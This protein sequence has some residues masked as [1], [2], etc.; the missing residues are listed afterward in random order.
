MKLPPRILILSAAFV[1]ILGLSTFATASNFKSLP[2]ISFIQSAHAGQS[3]VITDFPA[4]DF[5]LWSQS[6]VYGQDFMGSTDQSKAKQLWCTGWADPSCSNYDYLFADLILPPCTSDAQR[7]CIEGLEASGVDKVLKPLSFYQES[8]SQ[9]IAPYTF[10]GGTT[11]PQT[12]IPGGGGLS[13]WKSSELGT[14]GLAKLYGTHV[15]LRYIASCPP[16]RQSGAC[17]VSLSDFKGSVYP[18]T[19]GSGVCKEFTLSGNVCANSTNF[20]GDERVALTLRL[21]K[22][23]TGWIFGRMQNA[24][25]AVDPIDSSNNKIR[26]EGDVTLV[27]E[28]QASLPKSQIASDPALEKY[29]RDF[30]T[31]GRFGTGDPGAGSLDY[32]AN[33]LPYG[34]GHSVTYD[35]FLAANTTKLLSINFDKFKLF[36]AFEK[37]LTAYTPPASNNGRNIMRQT[38]S[39]FWNFGAAT[40]S[41]NNPC[42]ADKSHLHGL[43]VTNAPIYDKGP[44]TF[45]DGSL[46]YQVAGIHT[47]VD[48]SLFK[49]RYTYIVKSETARCYYHF[50]SAPIQAKVEIVSADNTN[51][52][53][54]TLISEKNGFIRLQAD[55]FTFSSPTIRVQLSQAPAKADNT[56]PAK[57][58]TPAI[59]KTITCLKGATTR[60]IT[61]SNPKCP[62][63]FKK[64]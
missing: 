28:L 40:Y 64:K 29:L 58:A 36:N 47:N 52:I 5:G 7:S 19:L 32:Q 2:A 48:G 53:A 27:P 15:L 26:I 22:N 46:N 18:I 21:D 43:V 30:Y 31:V 60:K 51:Q 35:G 23:L 20:T 33:D 50:S 3:N 41:G 1:A 37:H 57:L 34:N 12:N 56:S 54:T 44:P 61:S 8:V 55:N 63:G 11:G 16:S 13:V 24:D 62:S 14:N 9:K 6:S 42:S 59:S 25:F 49:G 17:S 45:T 10:N 39:I 38:N 4:D